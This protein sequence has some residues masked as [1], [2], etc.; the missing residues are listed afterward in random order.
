[1]K[2]KIILL[3]LIIITLSACKNN[4]ILLNK[5]IE[6]II[7]ENNPNY[8]ISINYPSTNIKKLDTILKKEIDDTIKLFKKE[9]VD[10]NN[11]E[12]I[13]LYDSNKKLENILLLPIVFK[14]I[15]CKLTQFKIIKS[16][17][18]FFF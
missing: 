17:I 12:V 11:K 18:L 15:I 13:G 7:E 4:N 6:T 2:T 16:H 14:R 3:F 8:L 1:M 5:N 9:Y 10:Y